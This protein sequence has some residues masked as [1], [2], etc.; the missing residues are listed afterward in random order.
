M[1]TNIQNTFLLLKSVWRDATLPPTT[2]SILITTFSENKKGLTIVVVVVVVEGDDDD[3]SKTFKVNV[4]VTVSGSSSTS[5]SFEYFC[6]EKRNFWFVLNED[7]ALER[8]TKDCSHSRNGKKKSK[9]K[10]LSPKGKRD[11][12]KSFGRKRD[13]SFWRVHNNKA[14]QLL[15]LPLLLLLLLCLLLLLLLLCLL[16]LCYC[17]NSCFVCSCCYVKCCCSTYGDVSIAVVD[18]AHVFVSSAAIYCCCGQFK[19]STV[20][21]TFYFTTFLE[22]FLSPFFVFFSYVLLSISY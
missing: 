21:L 19:H 4:N 11:F 15:L 9:Q 16:L 5:K 17:C 8:I 7:F 14:I 22:Y 3:L 12:G 1:T 2:K 10:K 18:C 13:S 6:F 20:F